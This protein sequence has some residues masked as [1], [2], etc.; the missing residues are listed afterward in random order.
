MLDK[1]KINTPKN[2]DVELLDLKKLIGAIVDYRWLIAGMTTLFLLLGIVYVLFSTPIYSADSLVQVEQEANNSILNNIER[3]MPSGQPDSAPEVELIQSRMILG[4]TVEDL[5]L[6]I[7]IN[8]KY[9]PIF[10]KGFARLTNAVPEM[11][12]VSQLQVPD[13]WFND[14]TI[15]LKVINNQNYSIIKN[16]EELFTGK[17]GLLAEKKGISLL[18]SDISAAPGSQFL[19]TKNTLLDA[20]NTIQKQLTVVDKGKSTGIL[21]LSFSGEDPV[22]IRKILDSITNNYFEQNVER[23]SE[24]DAKSLEFLKKQL[25]QI[26]SSLDSAEDKLSQYRQ[27]KYSV[28]LSMEAKSV[29]DSIV[30][31]DT[32][33][34]ALTFKEAEIS[35]LYTKEHPSY[36]T[37]IEQ[38]KTLEDEKVKLNQRVNL[39]PQTQQ[40][41]LRLSRDVQSGQVVYMQL[42]NKQQ[43]LNISKASTVGNVRIVDKAITQP[44]PIK[45]RKVIIIGIAVILGLFFS[46]SYVLINI[47][48]HQ[49]IKNPEQL[50]EL[51]ISVYASIPLSEWQRKRDIEFSVRHKK[52]RRNADTNVLLA[53]G[54]P[55]DL[56]VESIRSLRTS[57]HFAMLEAKNNIL[58]ISGASPGIG[59]TFIS[60]NL[61]AVIAQAG[62]RVLLIDSD[63]RKGY[64][65]ELFGV[66]GNNGLSDTLSGKIEFSETVKKID[67]K[68]HFDFIP[69][70]QVPPNPSELLMHPRLSVLLQW[71]SEHYDMV[72]IDTPPIL[73]VT[74][75]AIIGKHVGTALLVARFEVNSPK[76][77]EVSFRRFEQN[78]I[79]VKGV[80]LNAVVKR[81]GNYYNY[82][83][84]YYKYSEKEKT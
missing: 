76:E 57:L 7:T 51:G 45:P 28:D 49:G 10:G 23:R 69:C 72:L 59:K 15:I 62:L 67:N 9:F 48:L 29:L 30:S 54:N 44:L 60:A 1:N 4:K 25:P 56:A 14:S 22:L 37:L 21:Q 78:G 32:Q 34:N 11:L 27:N 33:L 35:K 77:I 19:I 6:T 31:V 41:I 40:E 42:L 43:E 16:G 61:A 39:M 47:F 68:D 3:L 2:D 53:F 38:R 13:G 70:G 46:L 52:I 81:A 24:E 75:A 73:A 26:R 82:G 65:H 36:R 50:E 79:D 66:S 20:I 64:T 83:Y 80:I 18:I 84:D 55:A 63:M 12:T 71:A 58:M 8:K 74:D 17:V 5:N